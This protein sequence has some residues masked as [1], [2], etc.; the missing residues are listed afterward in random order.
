MIFFGGG[1]VEEFKY[2]LVDWNSVCSPVRGG[3]LGIRWLS[4]FYQ[5]L[6]D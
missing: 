2:C 1:K 3:D 6:F 5:A 4:I